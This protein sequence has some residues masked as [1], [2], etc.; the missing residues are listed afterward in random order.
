MVPGEA[1]E[2]G[3]GLT[4]GRKESLIYIGGKAIKKLHD[5]IAEELTK[6][7]RQEVAKTIGHV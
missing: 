2:S 3:V 5:N 1:K 4:G 6:L 7:V